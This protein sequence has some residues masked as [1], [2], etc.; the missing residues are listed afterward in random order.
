VPSARSPRETLVAALPF[1]LLGCSTGTKWVDTLPPDAAKSAAAPSATGEARP[2]P[3]LPPELLPDAEAPRAFANAPVAGKLE[4]AKDPPKVL[5]RALDRTEVGETDAMDAG[6]LLARELL[7]G[8]A[9]WTRVELAPGACL[10]AAAHG[11]AG[12]LEVDVVVT[13]GDRR[14]ELLAIDPGNGPGAVVGGRTGCLRN[15]KAEPVTL[16]VWALARRGGGTVLLRVRTRK[17]VK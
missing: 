7:Q 1:A 8:H 10:A 3:P 4:P 13:R 2:P 14:S 5:V 9:A 11:G 16:D 6:P 15:D 17:A 12:L